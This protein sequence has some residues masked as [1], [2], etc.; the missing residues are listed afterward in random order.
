M[1][2]DQLIKVVAEKNELSK[3]DATEIVN[4]I[5]ETITETLASGEKVELYGF[6]KFEVRERAARKGRNPQ[7]PSEE[8]L[9]PAKKAPAFKALKGLKDAVK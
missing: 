9:I 8:I 6:G 3:K 4:S 1:K 7:N 2:K 5:L